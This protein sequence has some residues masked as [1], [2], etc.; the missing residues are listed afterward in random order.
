MKRYKTFDSIVGQSIAVTRLSESILAAKYGGEMISPLLM[1]ERGLGKSALARATIEGYKAEGLDTL[2]FE[3]AE[4]FR[5]AG[6]ESYTSLLSLIMDSKKW[7]LH[8][9]EAH[10][11]NY[12]ATVQLDKVKAFIMKALDLGNHGKAIRWDADTT[13]TFDRTRGSIVLD[14]NFPNLL[15]PSGA[16]QSRCNSI[17]LDLY[18]EKEMVD[19]LQVMLKNAGFQPANEQTLSLIA[20]CGR[21]S[22]RLLEKIIG[23]LKTTSQSH[24]KPKTTINRDDVINALKL[25]KLFPK[26]LQ[27]YEIN[28]LKIAQTPIRDNVLRAMLTQVEK[29]AFDDSK[30]YLMGIGFLGQTSK[31]VMR[32]DKGGRYLKDIVEAGF[33]I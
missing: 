8:I 16:F 9:G 31:G 4:E 2:S 10:L 23:Q 21:G 29:K 30:A 24:E 7:A 28:I 13:V 26:G 33:K 19:I 3:S 32:A 22:A 27:P 1:G 6:G 14:T 12:K 5:E 15:D 25:S 18:S 20:K 11:L 17:I